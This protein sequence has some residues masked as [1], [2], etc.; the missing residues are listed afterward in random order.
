MSKLLHGFIFLCAF[1][2][3][4]QAQVNQGFNRDIIKSAPLNYTPAGSLSGERGTILYDSIP[5]VGEHT[6]ISSVF[7]TGPFYFASADDFDVP[8]GEFWE[9]EQVRV[10]G[11]YVPGMGT[12]D[13]AS[14]VDILIFADN[15]GLPA[16]APTAPM[17]SRLD[18]DIID[19]GNTGDFIIDLSG[20]PLQLAEGTY[21]ISVVAQIGDTGAQWNWAEAGSAGSPVAG[22]ASAYW[23]DLNFNSGGNCVSQWGTRGTTC[24][25]IDPN[26]PPTDPDMSFRLSGTVFTPDVLVQNVTGNTVT[27]GGSTQTF[28][29]VL[30]MPPTNDVSVDISVDDATELSVS[31]GTLTFTSG[32]WDV[33]QTVTVTGVDDAIADGNV[34]SNVTLDNVTSADGNYNGITPSTDTLAFTTQDDEV[35]GVQVRVVTDATGATTTAPPFIV[36]EDNSV[37]GYVAFK[38]NTMPSADVTIPVSLSAQ[39]QTEATLSANSIVLTAANWNNNDNVITI[40]RVDDDVDEGTSTPITLITGNPSAPGDATYNA[41]EAGDV[42]DVAGQVNDDDTAGITVTPG[43]T[44]TSEG[45]DTGD[46]DVVLDSEPTADVSVV[47][48]SS[49]SSEGTVNPP[50]T[51]TFTSANWDTPQTVTVT[52]VDDALVDGDITYTIVTQAATSADPFYAGINPADVTMT[53]LNDDI[54]TPVQLHVTLGAPL[55]IT[56]GSEGCVVAI[57]NTNGSNDPNDWTF[58]AGGITLDMSGSAMV[59]GV[60]GEADT[61]YAVIADGDPSF[62]PLNQLQLSVPTLGEW[63]MLA[64][65]LGLMLFGVV[66]MRKGRV[67]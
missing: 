67:A 20:N 34:S 35:A 6:A 60:L 64:F 33:P 41:L 30:S 37:M 17:M 24:G 10:P 7:T 3:T 56:G 31:V 46:F 25:Y 13:P 57:Y 12:T 66:S 39:D 14:K 58:L 8:A 9:V 1:C 53:N 44:Q 21:W 18:R 19:P 63:G 65:V 4:A 26:D 48:F 52:G 42:A 59:N 2:V 54:C 28:E 29:V 50:T 36:E 27:E 61:I 45:G 47:V 62:T 32:N 16:S 51:L 22:N 55:Y 43:D 15:P 23:E 40:T 49:D 5:E 11:V 38:L